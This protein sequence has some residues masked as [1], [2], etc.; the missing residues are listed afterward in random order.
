MR[1]VASVGVLGGE[2]GAAVLKDGRV[3]VFGRNDEGELGQGS[4]GPEECVPEAHYPCS[5]KPLPLPNVTEAVAVSGGGDVGFV[6]LRGGTVMSW[7]RSQFGE[8]GNGEV[9]EEPQPVPIA[10]LHEVVAISATDAH[11]LALLRSGKVLAWGYGQNGELG[12]GKDANS[13]TPVEVDGLSEVVGIA[14]SFTSNLAVLRDGKV[15]TWGTESLD[16]GSLTQ[17]DVPVEAQGVSGAVAVAGDGENMVL[18]GNGRVLDWG[19]NRHGE[20]GDGTTLESAT[21]VEVKGLEHVVAIAGSRGNG[22]AIEQQGPPPESSMVEEPLPANRAA[23][24]WNALH[25]PLSITPPA[26]PP[27]SLAGGTSKV[28]AVVLRRCPA[29]KARSA[30]HRRRAHAGPCVGRRLRRRL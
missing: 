4:A 3:L 17:S 28:H 14:A 18:L 29:R 23:L 9:Q 24:E 2:D 6:L 27:F 7:G 21:P 8:L 16:H 30:R 11:C 10:G 26:G 1:E 5:T 25:G 19:E 12:D 13:G 22:Y 20:L 15:M